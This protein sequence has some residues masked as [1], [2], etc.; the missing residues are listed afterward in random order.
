MGLDFSPE[1]LTQ[2]HIVSPSNAPVRVQFCWLHHES[3]VPSDTF[4]VGLHGVRTTPVLASVPRAISS[5]L[6]AG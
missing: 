3:I 2:L 1:H 4:A 5:S 6:A